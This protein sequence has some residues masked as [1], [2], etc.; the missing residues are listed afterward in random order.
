MG[1]STEVLIARRERER[2]ARE[3]ERRAEA[4]EAEEAF[5]HP[6]DVLAEEVFGPQAPDEEE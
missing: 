3:A 4:G 6:A 1:K 5:N 2:K